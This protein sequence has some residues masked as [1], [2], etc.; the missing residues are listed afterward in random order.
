ME[1]RASGITRVAV[2]GGNGV[3]DS[4][5]P[6]SG[7]NGVLDSQGHIAWRNRRLR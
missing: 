5:G 6:V 4:H 3:L 7:V 1:K 2:H